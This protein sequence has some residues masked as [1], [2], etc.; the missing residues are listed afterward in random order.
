V[1]RAVL[2]AVTHI[3]VVATDGGTKRR[4]YSG[5]DDPFARGAQVTIAPLDGSSLPP[6]DS[7]IQPSVEGVRVQGHVPHRPHHDHS[8]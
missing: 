2:V 4:R 3:P 5:S 6:G 1:V 7:P 8:R